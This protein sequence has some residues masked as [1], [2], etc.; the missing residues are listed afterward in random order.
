MATDR[1]LDEQ[2][3][4]QLASISDGDVFRVADNERIGTV[5]RDAVYGLQGELIGYLGPLGDGTA[6]IPEKF[7]KLLLGEPT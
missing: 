7:K 5:R 1:I 6:T 2:T 3:G 4:N